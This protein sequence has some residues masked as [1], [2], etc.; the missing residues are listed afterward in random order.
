VTPR[1]IP[2]E[3]RKGTADVD[4][5][6]VEIVRMLNENG[7][8]VR[9][10]CTDGDSTGVHKLGPAFSTLVDTSNCDFL[11]PTH[12]ETELLARMCDVGI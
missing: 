11:D 3:H 12:R 8:C 6:I 7:L 9:W 2:G 1:V 4:A 5:T 10:V